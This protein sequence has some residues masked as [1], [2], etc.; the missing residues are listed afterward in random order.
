MRAI[1]IDT[2]GIVREYDTKAY[3]KEHLEKAM[4]VGKMEG[5]C[6]IEANDNEEG[7]RRGSRTS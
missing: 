4:R 2:S 6:R 7:R 5:A 1:V 3:H